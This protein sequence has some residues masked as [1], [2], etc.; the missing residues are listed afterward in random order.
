MMTVLHEQQTSVIKH[1][2]NFGLLS[3]VWE[4]DGKATPNNIY[5]FLSYEESLSSLLTKTKPK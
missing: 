2:D 1:P 5:L 4:V 3:Y